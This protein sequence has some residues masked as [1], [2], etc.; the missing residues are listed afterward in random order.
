[1]NICGLC[2]EQLE[3]G[4]LCVGCTKSTRVRLEALPVLHRGLAALLAPAGGRVQ[5]RR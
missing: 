4:Y 3:D 5:G 1:M 2:E